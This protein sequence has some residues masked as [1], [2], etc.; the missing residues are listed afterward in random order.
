[1]TL[2]PLCSSV[3]R[4]VTYPRRCWRV[5]AHDGMVSIGDQ[6]VLAAAFAHREENV[7]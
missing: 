4:I 3:L 6:F 1:V 2:E 7:R 5:E